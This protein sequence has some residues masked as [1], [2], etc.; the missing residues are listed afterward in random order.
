ML[1]NVT[2]RCVGGPA[3]ESGVRPAMVVN[4]HQVLERCAAAEAAA[5]H[6]GAHACCAITTRACPSLPP[7]RTADPGRGIWCATRWRPARAVSLTRAERNV[8]I[9]NRTPAGVRVEW[10]M[11]A[12]GVR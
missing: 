7:M 1:Q 6:E 11:T 4:V 3:A 2:A 8:L 5:Q 10:R 12:A 9:G